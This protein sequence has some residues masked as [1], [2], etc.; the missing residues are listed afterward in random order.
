MKKRSASVAI[1]CDGDDEAA[2]VPKKRGSI[3]LNRAVPSEVPSLLQSSTPVAGSHTGKYNR[4]PSLLRYRRLREFGSGEKR[5]TIPVPALIP[6]VRQRVSLPPKYSTP[7]IRTV[8][9]RF[10][11][12]AGAT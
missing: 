10:G 6:S 2:S 7:S 11:S 1:K 5:L 12:T 9:L 8:V 4:E 3:S